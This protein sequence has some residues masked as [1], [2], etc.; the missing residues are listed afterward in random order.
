MENHLQ[1][2]G[3]LVWGW[4]MMAAFI[5]VG[6]LFTVRLRGLQFRKLPLAFRCIRTQSS[7]GISPYAALCTALAATIGTGNIVG[8]AT[9]LAAGGPG[10]LFWILIAAFFGMATQYAE[11]FLAVK[12]RKKGKNGWFGGPFC[13]IEQGLGRRWKWL[14]VLYASIGAAVGVLGVGT[15]TQVNSITGTADA[16]F[17]SEIAF[18]IGEKG[19][20]WATV[21]T[22]AIVTVAAALVLLGGVSRITNVCQTLVPVMSAAYLLFSAILLIR[23]ADRIPSAVK[24]I[25]DSAFSPR[26]VLGGVTGITL[27]KAMRMGIGRGVFTNEAGLGSSAIAAGVSE[28]RD[29]VRQGLV[30]M[31]GTF[32]DTI[33]ICTVTGLC[34]VVTGAWNVP[35]E[36]VGI[37]DYAWRIGLPWQ[38][39]LSS[40]VLMVCLIF[41]AFATIIGWNFYAEQCVCYLTGE[42]TRIRTVYRWLY[43][44]AIAAGPYFTVSA[45][46]ELADILNA[47]MALPNLAALLLLQNSIVSDTRR[48]CRSSKC[49]RK[50]NSD[51]M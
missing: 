46:W 45:A 26:A 29:P 5:G 36:G 13:Y 38:E 33:V 32:I 20:S 43:L 19:Y 9:A 27:K 8:V 21:I 48:A 10:A 15:V 39:S 51:I 6:L 30:T 18:V 3:E 14:A 11:G 42:R 1:K 35:V 16:F 34:L 31:T 24:L 23:F 49:I 28:E 44:L 40:F 12:Y 37:T 7:G 22:G 4:P 25:L 41:F 50:N 2:I 17:S 47:V